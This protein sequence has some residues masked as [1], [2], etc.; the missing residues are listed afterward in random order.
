MSS[1]KTTAQHKMSGKKSHHGMMGGMGKM[2]NQ[3]KADM[4]DKMPMDQKMAAMNGGS[5][6]H[7][8]AKKMDH[9]DK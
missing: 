6:M 7:H 8:G 1:D 4:F 5:G 9:M 3:E 2:S